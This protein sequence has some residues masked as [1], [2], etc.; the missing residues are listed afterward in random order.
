MQVRRWFEFGRQGTDSRGFDRFDGSMT[1]QKREAVI[2]SFSAPPSTKKSKTK[3]KKGDKGPPTVM[4]I[5]LKVR[6]GSRGERSEVL[7]YSCRLVR[8]D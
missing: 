7:M 8:W 3:P 2:S 5:S 6:L 4:L 1:Q